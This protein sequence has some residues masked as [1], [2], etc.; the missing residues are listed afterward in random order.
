MFFEGSLT[1]TAWKITMIP[2]VGYKW[3]GKGGLSEWGGGGEGA[4]D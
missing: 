1:F 2:G 3:I 4:H